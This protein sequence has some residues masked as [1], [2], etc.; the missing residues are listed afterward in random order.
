M[1]T[2]EAFGAGVKRQWSST[3]QVNAFGA[4]TLEQLCGV[5]K[6]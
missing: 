6:H 4:T 2:H 3:L 1:G 5:A